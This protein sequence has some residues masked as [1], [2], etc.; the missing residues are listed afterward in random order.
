MPV[1]IGAGVGASLLFALLA[2]LPSLGRASAKKTPILLLL[3]AQ[4]VVLAFKLVGR[5]A[6]MLPSNR[7]PLTVTK[8]L[9]ALLPPPELT[10]TQLQRLPTNLFLFVIVVSQPPYL[11][12][13]VRPVV[14]LPDPPT[15]PA[16][17]GTSIVVKTVTIVTITMSLTTAKFPPPAPA[18][19]TTNPSSKPPTIQTLSVEN[20]IKPP[21]LHKELQVY[22]YR[23]RSPT[24]NCGNP[25]KR[26]LRCPLQ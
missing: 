11:P 4:L 6:N 12:A 1:A 17:A 9:N 20:Q 10:V 21:T 23:Q 19:P 18:A 16:N 5:L 24:Y 2:L 3:Q 15:M 22:P 14:D 13:T 25:F 8:Q 26:P 7:F